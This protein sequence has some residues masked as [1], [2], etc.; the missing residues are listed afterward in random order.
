MGSN[1]VAVYWMDIFAHLFVVK[2]VLFVLKRPK[3]NEKEAGLAHFYKKK[4]NVTSV[5]RFAAKVS[6]YP[7][8]FIALFSFWQTMPKSLHSKQETLFSILRLKFSRANLGFFLSLK[9]TA[10]SV[11]RWLDYFAQ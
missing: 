2:I 4:L 11:T 1:P 9:W 7:K 3:I 10:V 5:P 8:P 6:F